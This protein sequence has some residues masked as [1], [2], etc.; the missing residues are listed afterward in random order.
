M[1]VMARKKSN[2]QWLREVQDLVGDSF[3]PLSVY[4]G[5]KK[6]VVIYHVDCGR[7]FYMSP[8]SFLRGQRCPKCG[9]ISRSLKQTQTQKEFDAEIAKIN[10]GRYKILTPY[11]DDQTPLEVECLVCHKH[12]HPTPHNLKVGTGCPRCAGSIVTQED[13]DKRV[14][15]KNNGQF[16][17]S[18]PYKNTETKMTCHCNLCGFEWDISPHEFYNIKGCPQCQ[19]NHVYTKDEF[20]FKLNRKYGDEYRLVEKYT[21]K[22]IKLKFYHKKCDDYF[23]ARPADL[24]HGGTGCPHCNQS[25]GE[26]KIR[27]Y[28]RD[29]SILFI[30]QKRFIDCKYKRHLPFDFYI[31]SLRLAIE[32]DGAQHTQPNHFKRDINTFKEGQ[33]RD[34]IKDWYCRSHHIMLIRI[35]YTAKTLD[36][37]KSYLYV[38]S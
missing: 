2:S 35:P 20:N 34:H 1:H 6:K 36:Q 32:Y 10:H 33:L 4:D 16:S 17:F 11:I 19:T 26:M 14:E 21:P 23:D 18:E 31:P 28:L 27:K 8:N 7:I 22:K 15:A 30:E 24:L 12:F 38:L 37:I 13:F 9:I 3:V 29:R 5:N 25:K